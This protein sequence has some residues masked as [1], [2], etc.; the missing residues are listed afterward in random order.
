MTYHTPK[1]PTDHQLALIKERF[2]LVNGIVVV[3]TKYPHSP[4]VGEQAGGDNGRGYLRIR[5]A[6]R[7]MCI[8]NA[9]WFLYHGFWPDQMLDHIDGNPSNND[10]TNLRLSS[11]TKNQRAFKATKKNA[12][13][14]FRGVHRIARDS[15][16]RAA[17][18]TRGKVK[19]LGQFNIEAEAAVAYDFGAAVLHFDIQ[20]LNLLHHQDE[21]MLAVPQ[22]RR[23]AIQA[24]ASERFAA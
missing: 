9:A 14:K 23:L 11:G 22:A 21:L 16:W 5:V 1:R 18:S 7:L 3:K 24:D 6:G 15:K 12:S 13:S 10:P 8:H 4:E 20:S 2:E 17:I 19:H